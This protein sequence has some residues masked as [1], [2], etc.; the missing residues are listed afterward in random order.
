MFQHYKYTANDSTYHDSIR[1][2]PAHYN[3]MRAKPILPQ[4]IIEVN[5]KRLTFGFNIKFKTFQFVQNNI[6]GLRSF[7]NNWIRTKDEWKY[8]RDDRK[9]RKR[10]LF[11]INANERI[12]LASLDTVSNQHLLSASLKLPQEDD[13]FRSLG[14]KRNLINK[15][16]GFFEYSPGLTLKLI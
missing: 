12:H 9:F 5:H 15:R 2:N 1:A 4:A 14:Q 7:P 16:N 10:C 11:P 13:V 3:S 6:K 8:F